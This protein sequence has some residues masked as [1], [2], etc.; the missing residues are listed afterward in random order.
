MKR[1]WLVL[2][3]AAIGS[4]LSGCAEKS[5]TPLMPDHGARYDENGGSLGGGGRAA[6]TAAANTVSDSTMSIN[7][8]SLGGGGR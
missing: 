5:A 8:G 7:G 3:C 4:M 6:E 2:S 1:L